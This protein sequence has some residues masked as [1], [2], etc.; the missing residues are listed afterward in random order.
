VINAERLGSTSWYLIKHEVFVVWLILSIAV[1]L[2]LFLLVGIPV[3]CLYVLMEPY[4]KD[5]HEKRY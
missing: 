3:L 1:L 5:Q 2:D 4:M